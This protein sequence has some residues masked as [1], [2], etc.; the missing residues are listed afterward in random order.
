MIKIK[1]GVFVVDGSKS[2]ICAELSTIIHELYE[3]KALSKKEIEKSMQ[4]AFLSES[5][6]EEEMKKAKKEFE[7]TKKEDIEKISELIK[8]LL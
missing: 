3:G 2:E 6:L 1:N 5:E 7:Q 4:L 8:E